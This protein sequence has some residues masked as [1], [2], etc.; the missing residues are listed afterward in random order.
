M[1]QLALTSNLRYYLPHWAQPR[2]IPRHSS[3]GDRFEKIA[4][5]GHSTNLAP[6]LQA[7]HWQK[8]LEA[9]GLEWVRVINHNRWDNYHQI[10]NRWND[11]REIDAVVAVRSFNPRQTYPHKP[12][13]KLYNA[14]LSGVP[15]I[16][17][18]ESAYQIE[19]EKNVNYLEV[20]SLAELIAALKRLKTNPALRHIL[21]K[22]GWIR[23]QDFTSEVITQKWHNFL[24]EIA[25]PT[26]YK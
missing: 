25:I 12:A 11:Y 15:A 3:R 2:L 16:L 9:L 17:G 26:F 21:V 19:G 13:T 18:A 8:Q 22:N 7:P 20:T 5:F 14:W 6:E 1:Q 23:A 4:F 10:D 24:I